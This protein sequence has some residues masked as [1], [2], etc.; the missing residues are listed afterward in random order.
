M[1][2]SVCPSVRPSVCPYVSTLFPGSVLS[3][4]RPIFFKLCIEDHIG[5]E[6]FGNK[7]GFISSNKYRVMTL[8]LIYNFVS[9][10]YLEHLFTNFLQ[11]LHM[12]SYREGVV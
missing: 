4:Y 10:L 8:D 11:T 1:R 5:K 9:E 12:S 6:W 3:I 7:D 2:T